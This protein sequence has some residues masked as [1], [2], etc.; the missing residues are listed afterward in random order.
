MLRMM[1]GLACL[2]AGLAA[3][4][5][6]EA[7]VLEQPVSTLRGSEAGSPGAPA[8]AAGGTRNTRKRGTRPS[9]KTA[10]AKAGLESLMAALKNNERIKELEEFVALNTK[11]NV[12]G[13]Q[14]RQTKCAAA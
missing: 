3:M 13:R 11:A 7:L 1:V 14:T 6:R 10:P 9:Q 2:M 4:W 8:V 12:G 5:A